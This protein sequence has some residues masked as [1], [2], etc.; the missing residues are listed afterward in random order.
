M[1][2]LAGTGSFAQSTSP[3]NQDTVQTKKIPVV[4]AKPYAKF[5]KRNCNPD[6]YYDSAEAKDLFCKANYFFSRKE[7]AKSIECLKQAFNEGFSVEFKFHVM[8]L[9]MENY[10]ALGDIK[11]ADSYK[12]KLDKILEEFPDLGN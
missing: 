2:V 9:L 12:S 6:K 3:A 7:N 11:L 5:E 8:K 10:R 1:I 4:K